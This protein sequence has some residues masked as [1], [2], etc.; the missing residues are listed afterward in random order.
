MGPSGYDDFDVAVEGEAAGFGFGGEL[1][2]D[3]GLEME[4]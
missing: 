3:L 2:F 4:V 1:G